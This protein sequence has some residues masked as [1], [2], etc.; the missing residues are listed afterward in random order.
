MERKCL[1]CG[2]IVRGRIDK[3]FCS[4]SCRNSYNNKMYR[5]STEYVR[6]V[7]GKLRKNRRILYNLYSK[8]K[9][10]V[11]KETLMAL[12]F[13]FRFFSHMV[14][15]NGI[16]I[17]YCFEYGFDIGSDSYDDLCFNDKLFE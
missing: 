4:D 2:A 11:H 10:K 17:N 6:K 8:N 7:Y 15:N 16:K 5:D 3:K 14:E 9:L 12:G 13:D 1:D